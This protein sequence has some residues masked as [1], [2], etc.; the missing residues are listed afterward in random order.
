MFSNVKQVEQIDGFK[1]T[2][3]KEGFPGRMWYYQVE[4][5][6]HCCTGG[7]YNT[8]EEATA[9]RSMRCG[10]C[11]ATGEHDSYPAASL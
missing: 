9:Q 4:Q 5:G 3:K 7:P 10:H 11:K 1:V 6:W 8:A 2:I